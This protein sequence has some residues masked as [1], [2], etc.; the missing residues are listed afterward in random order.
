MGATRVSFHAG[1]TALIIAHSSEMAAAK[2]NT[3]QLNPIS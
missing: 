1:N 3:R 2:H